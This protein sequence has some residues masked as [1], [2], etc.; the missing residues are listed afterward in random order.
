M[1]YS[2]FVQRFTQG[3]SAPLNEGLA[4]EILRPYLVADQGEP[5]LI[6]AEDGGE[7]EVYGDSTGLMFDRPNWGKIFDI[8]ADLAEQLGAVVVMPGSPTLMRSEADREDLPA[9]LR[10]EATVLEWTGS[11][12]QSVLKEA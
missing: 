7:A 4:R 1:S 6:R 11:A 3:Q 12:I 9:E 8:V 5:L 2:I 10:D